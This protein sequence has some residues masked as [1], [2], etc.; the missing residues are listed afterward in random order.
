MNPGSTLMQ[1]VNAPCET[2]LQPPEMSAND[3]LGADPSRQRRPVSL[4][5]DFPRHDVFALVDDP[6]TPPLGATSAECGQLARAMTA[7]AGWDSDA[8]VEELVRNA[9]EAMRIQRQL[10]CT[11]ASGRTLFER[12]LELGDAPVSIDELKTDYEFD[13]K[14]RT[15]VKPGES[16]DVYYKRQVDAEVARSVN[17]FVASL[18]NSL[19]TLSLHDSQHDG[20]VAADARSACSGVASQ[21]TEAMCN[22]HSNDGTLADRL[23]A[24]QKVHVS[25]SLQAHREWTRKT[26]LRLQAL[27]RVCSAV[28]DEFSTAVQKELEQVRALCLDAPACF[29]AQLQQRGFS[30]A[31]LHHC[32]LSATTSAAAQGA[33]LLPPSLGRVVDM[34]EELLTNRQAR[35][36]FQSA[37]V[38]AIN[39]LRAES[40]Q[41]EDSPAWTRTLV[42]DDAEARA[43]IQAGHPVDAAVSLG[44]PSHTGLQTVQ[45]YA[46]SQGGGALRVPRLLHVLQM[47]VARGA[48][49]VR[50][51]KAS[52]L[53]AAVSRTRSDKRFRAAKLGEFFV[54]RDTPLDPVQSTV[55]VA[56]R[57]SAPPTP[58][59]A[60]ASE[61]V[62]VAAALQRDHA[63]LVALRR[64][65][66]VGETPVDVVVSMLRREGCY[67][68]SQSARSVQQSVSFVLKKI[69]ARA[70]SFKPTNIAEGVIELK[71]DGRKGG[72]RLFCDEEGARTMRACIDQL[73]RSMQAGDQRI[74]ATWHASRTSRKRAK[75]R[76]VQ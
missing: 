43:R 12:L 55:A 29:V 17:A 24:L 6:A 39:L 31:V 28:G 59:A 63:I 75:T 51:L 34:M 22:E 73:V 54:L 72:T 9:V 45:L 15:R 52:I 21:L 62:A 58:R 23:A 64:A 50:V 53:S 48:L 65:L 49:R 44:T 4:A 36:A 19:L 20:I 11:D 32:V 68:A 27:S 35:R 5:C 14:I 60:L 25:R 41:E 2:G 33:S 76:A 38:S 10:S 40:Q 42:C 47:M 56:P 67:C 70:E 66:R 3:T 30:L 74:E 26:V 61:T 13:F 8:G 37:C 46:V 57:P 16:D 18:D 7:I 1:P 69:I 71:S